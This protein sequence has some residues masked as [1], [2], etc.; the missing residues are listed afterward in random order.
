MRVHLPIRF[1]LPQFTKASDKRFQKVTLK[2]GF[3]QR[4]KRHVGDI[5]YLD[6]TGFGT[7]KFRMLEVP[8]LLV[9]LAEESKCQCF[10]IVTGGT[11][12]IPF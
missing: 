2:R 11:L 3:V 1:E 5:T 8:F 12:R 6:C 9:E 4:E 7:R 10:R